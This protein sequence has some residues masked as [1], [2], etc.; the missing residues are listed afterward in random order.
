MLYFTSLMLC[1]LTF[2]NITKEVGA[3]YGIDADL[4]YAIAKVESNLNPKAV[5]SSHGEIGLMQLHPKYFPKASFEPR[6]NVEMAA[7]YIKK[8]KTACSFRAAAWITCY[9]TGVNH[10]LK[11]PLTS[12]YYKKV[13]DAYYR[14]KASTGQLVSVQN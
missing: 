9:N 11:H 2:S 12:K 8:L 14:R 5:G 1:S 6:K 13:M 4:L 3:K 7:A 10:K